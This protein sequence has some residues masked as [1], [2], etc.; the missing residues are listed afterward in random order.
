MDLNRRT[1][2]GRLS[3]LLGEASLPADRF[4]RRLGLSDVAA[5]AAAG[6]DRRSTEI[7]GWYREGIVAGAETLIRPFEHDVLGVDPELPADASE[8]AR[9]A[10]SISLLW[11]FRLTGGWLLRLVRDVVHDRNG[12]SATSAGAVPGGVAAQVLDALQARL[13]QVATLGVGSGSNAWVVPAE[14]AVDGKPLLAADP[15]LETAV[16]GVWMA[17]HVS[18]PG[19]NV[20]G[21]SVAGVPHVLLGHNGRVGWVL[22]NAPLD[23]AELCLEELSP[24][25]TAARRDGAWEPV[26]TVS[27]SIAVRGRAPEILERRR[28]VNGPLLDLGID[29]EPRLDVSFRWVLDGLVPDLAAH[30]DLLRADGVDQARQ[31]LRRWPFAPQRALVADTAGAIGETLAGFVPCFEQGGER[32]GLVPGW[33]R[34][35]AP[36]GVVPADDLG[37]PPRDRGA[38]IVAANQDPTGGGHL[39]GRSGAWDAGHRARRLQE[40]LAPPRPLTTGDCVRA[41]LDTFS[42]VAR[43]VLPLLLEAAGDAGDG[44]TAAAVAVLRRWDLRMNKNSAGAVVF[45][46]WLGRLLA[47]GDPSISPSATSPVRHGWLSEWGYRWFRTGLA[48]ARHGCGRRLLADALAHVAAELEAQ[49]GPSPQRWEWGRCHR[50][51]YRHP[52]ASSSDLRRLLDAGP[53]PVSGADDTVWRGDAEGGA[54]GTIFRLIVDFADF[55]RSVWSFPLGNS[56]NPGSR[57]YRDQAEFWVSGRYHPMWYRSVERVARD[58][59]TLI[60]GRPAEDGT[61]S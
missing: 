5:R 42:P 13:A 47:S 39:S 41:Q 55:E 50:A 1:A 3:E 22:T 4:F 20:I 51:H 24:D 19:M 37:L 49:Q 27:E 17:V 54:A 8:A 36:T 29:G 15:H 31:A 38:V 40:L 9:D 57:H 60:P 30:E 10:V 59:L 2:Q 45:A 12:E 7:F 33:D 26:R 44:S 11:S 48:G 21:A 28:T 58:V 16:P 43:E 18:G 25:G 32:P 6:L 14:R 56:G 46:R 34:R 23:V 53:Y 35:W 52:L 61:D